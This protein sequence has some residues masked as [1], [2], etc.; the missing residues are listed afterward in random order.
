MATEEPKPPE[1]PSFKAIQEKLDKENITN[2]TSQFDKMVHSPEW[3]L[4]G[5]TFHY[6][7][8]SHSNIKKRK[9]L[10]D[11]DVDETKDWDKYVENYYQ[12]SLLL[13]QEMTKEKFD[14]LPFYDIE[15]LVTAWSVRSRRGFC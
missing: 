6:K 3:S 12:R 8:Q 5:D 1:D 11:Q 9:A 14:E 10:E 4:N 7:I 15:N 2:Y 13:I